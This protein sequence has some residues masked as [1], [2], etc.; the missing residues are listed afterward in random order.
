MLK[1]F[2]ALAAVLLSAPLYAVDCSV[3]KTLEDPSNN[4]LN[5]DD[6]MG[7]NRKTLKDGALTFTLDVG[8]GRKARIERAF[9]CADRSDW[10]P[11]TSE[12]FVTNARSIILDVTGDTTASTPATFRVWDKQ[13]HYREWPLGVI[14]GNKHFELAFPDPSGLNVSSDA[15]SRGNIVAGF[16]IEFDRTAEGNSWSLLPSKTLQLTLRNLSFSPSLPTNSILQPKPLIKLAPITKD[17][18]PGSYGPSNKPVHFVLQ[19]G[20]VSYLLQLNSTCGR[21]EQI[22]VAAGNSVPLARCATDDVDAAFAFAKLVYSRAC[23]DNPFCKAELVLGVDGIRWKT[24]DDGNGKSHE[25]LR[26]DLEMQRLWPR[27][28]LRIDG[29]TQKLK[30]AG[31]PF[32]FAIGNGHGI[33]VRQPGADLGEDFLDSPYAKGFWLGETVT[34]GKTEADHSL[35]NLPGSTSVSGQQVLSNVLDFTGKRKDSKG[36]TRTDAK[37]LVHHRMSNAW[38]IQDLFPERLMIFDKQPSDKTAIFKN[39]SEVYVPAWEMLEPSSLSINLATVLGYWAGGWVNEFGVS[40]QSWGWENMR[41]G[42]TEDMRAHDWLRMWTIGVGTGAN[43]IQVEPIWAFAGNCA[44][45]ET[46]K[47]PFANTGVTLESCNSA[48][49]DNLKAN[50][51]AMQVFQKWVEWGVVIAADKPSNLKSLNGP[52][53]QINNPD[54]REF[55]S[56]A[57][58]NMR[59][60]AGRVFNDAEIRSRPPWVQQAIPDSCKSGGSVDECTKQ[61]GLTGDHTSALLTISG[62]DYK[63]RSR[64]LPAGDIFGRIHGNSHVYDGLFP[65]T[66]LGLIPIVGV[67]TP[68][69]PTPPNGLNRVQFSGANVALCPG[70]TGT[71]WCNSTQE[72]GDFLIQ[73][74]EQNAKNLNLVAKGG[75]ATLIRMEG[76]R[77]VAYLYDTEHRFPKGADI[78]LELRGP[79]LARWLIMDSVTGEDLRD[80]NVTGSWSFY[81]N[82]WYWSPSKRTGTVKVAPGGVRILNILLPIMNEDP[83]ST[84]APWQTGLLAGKSSISDGSSY[85]GT[86]VPIPDWDPLNYKST[87]AHGT[88]VMTGLSF[89]KDTHMMHKQLCTYAPNIGV[90]AAVLSGLA[91]R[92]RIRRTGSWTGTDW[93]PHFYKWQCGENEYISGVSQTTSLAE[94]HAVRCSTG[95]GQVTGCEV[96]RAL[97][98][99]DRGSVVSGEW[100]AGFHKAECPV[101]KV[102]VGL[103]ISPSTLKVNG[104]MCCDQ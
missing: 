52:A 11:E 15:G 78:Q 90:Q 102:V 62:T 37:V 41:W 63:D 17:I 98:G 83:Y 4:W 101:K 80:W 85:T 50:I 54:H 24:V 53:L 44:L 77:Y 72:A 104:L 69:T 19:A 60:P 22:A 97:S 12:R 18:A 7:P 66:P 88:Y 65:Q 5:G 3:V 1:K 26:T 29:I 27:I 35:F 61:L 81:N 14:A 6:W 2:A 34:E 67:P 79:E 49:L 46:E 71:N 86:N 84:V 36:V 94:V 51:N 13:G 31:I 55:N 82:R 30:A 68:L 76:G 96:K 99:D 73:R 56:V 75:G 100:D 25:E 21:A 16:H 40:T 74:I 39:H 58:P 43:Y 64:I 38:W 48:D 20:S 23:P 32:Y 42:R 87:C 91:D 103:S 89:V 93:D 92:Q 59:P 70:G 8:V 45:E 33:D 47:V 9:S 10:G 57:I 28:R 95:F